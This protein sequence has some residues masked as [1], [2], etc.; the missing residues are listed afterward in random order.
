MVRITRAWVFAGLTLLSGSALAAPCGGFTDVDDTVY[1]SGFNTFCSGVEWVKNRSVTIGCTS[2]TTYCPS[3]PVNRAQMALFMQRLGFALEPTILY[4]EATIAAGTDFTNITGYCVVGPYVVIGF[5]R[6]ATVSGW[7]LAHPTGA[8]HLI[9][10]GGVYSTDGGTTWLGVGG[11]NYFSGVNTSP[12]AFGSIPVNT[13]SQQLSVGQS[14][15]FAIGIGKFQ[16]LGLSAAPTDCV[17]SVR[18][19][20]R[21]PVTPPYDA[22]AGATTTTGGN[23]YP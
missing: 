5:P 3:A 21:N 23:L 10:A 8:T 16:G 13:A 18:I 4:R 22:A 6:A 1:G 20:N 14:V 17:I 12:S 19:D 11:A 9:G 2:P 7:A 15:L